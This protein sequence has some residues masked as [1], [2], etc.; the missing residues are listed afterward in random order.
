MAAD[1][2]MA[3]NI[4][5]Y[6]KK[7]K[8]EEE[9]KKEREEKIKVNSTNCFWRL[10]T[11]LVAPALQGVKDE[12]LVFDHESLSHFLRLA[13]RLDFDD[14]DNKD[15]LCPY[16][17]VQVIIDTGSFTVQFPG[18]VHIFLIPA[19]KVDEIYQDWFFYVME[20]CNLKN[21]TGFAML[22]L[23]LFFGLD[24]QL[25]PESIGE[26]MKL[27]KVKK[28]C[29]DELLEKNA[30]HYQKYWLNTR[31][32]SITTNHKIRRSFLFSL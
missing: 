31:D 30:G 13:R 17:Y 5:S 8:M 20:Q 7:M 2:E 10:N 1:A 32:S 21:Q 27:D 4:R 3:R 6:N 19:A 12:E 16:E 22:I 14:I 9:E 11:T 15:F 23:A 24:E 26:A 18:R 29:L 28:T 25:T